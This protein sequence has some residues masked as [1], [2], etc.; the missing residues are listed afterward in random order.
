VAAGRMIS[1]RKQLW[2]TGRSRAISSTV[3]QPSGWPSYKAIPLINS[4]NVV[5]SRFNSN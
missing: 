1:A 5:H 4:G 3:P 2:K